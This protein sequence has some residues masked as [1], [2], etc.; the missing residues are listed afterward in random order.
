MPPHA[1]TFDLWDTLV[2]DDS[3]EP[4][5]AAAGL[6]SKPLARAARF[7]ALLREAHPDLPADRVQAAWDHAQERFRHAW[8]VEHHTPGVAWRLGQAFD[9]LG[10]AAPAETDACVADIESMEVRFAPDPAPHAVAVL[11]ALHGRY[12][13]AIISDAIVT[14]GLLLRDVMKQHGLARYFDAFIFSDEAGAAKPARAVFD[15]A[16]AALGVPVTGLVHVGDREANDIAGPHG[17]GARAVLYTGVIDRGSETSAADIICADHRDLPAQLD[18]LL[19][20]P[21]P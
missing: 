14:P 17:V 18:A 10:I 12:P 5:R 16:A 6:Q 3:D 7:A 9:Q 8:K 19:A 21:H 11:Q 13:L 2:I 1:I 20:A 15:Q 4:R